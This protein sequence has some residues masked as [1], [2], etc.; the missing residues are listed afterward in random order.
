MMPI[1]EIQRLPAFRQLDA[2]AQ[3]ATVAVPRTV[4]ELEVRHPV[5]SH[6]WVELDSSYDHL[7]MQAEYQR[8]VSQFGA[9]LRL[10]HQRRM[11]MTSAPDIPGG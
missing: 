1:E 2:D 10:K 11:I 3:V 4:W 5:E 9:R 6:L 7:E 8:L